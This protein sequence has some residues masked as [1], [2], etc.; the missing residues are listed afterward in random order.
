VSSSTRT[1]T[2]S[3]AL[4]TVLGK[5]ARAAEPTRTS[6]RHRSLLPFLAERFATVYAVGCCRHLRAG[7][8]AAGMSSVILPNAA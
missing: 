6:V 3:K 8:V 2:T 7:A 4:L 1:A 5:L